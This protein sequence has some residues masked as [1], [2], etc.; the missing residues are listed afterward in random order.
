MIISYLVIFN[1]IFIYLIECNLC[2]RQCY[3]LPC[4]YGLKY[5]DKKVITP[6]LPKN[7][8]VLDTKLYLIMK[9]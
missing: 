2:S 6:P 3:D 1:N 5:V 7:R 4:R 9:L 8:G